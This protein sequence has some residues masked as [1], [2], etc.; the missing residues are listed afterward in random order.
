MRNSLIISL[1]I[2][3]SYIQPILSQNDISSKY[4]FSTIS[5]DDG[6][7]INFVDDIYKDSRGFIWIST[8]G[9]GLVRYDGYEFVPLNVNSYPIS[10]K[11]NFIRKVCEDNYNRLWIASNNGIDI[12]S[13]P[14]MMKSEVYYK[15]NLFGELSKIS[16]STII[17]DSKGS[18]WILAT[19]KI[20][21]LDFDEKGNIQQIYT[22]DSLVAPSIFSTIK[23]IDS[24]I[25]VGHDGS[26]CKVVADETKLLL[27]P[28]ADIPSQGANVFISSV[29]KKGDI[30]WIGTEYGLLKYNSKNKTE[31]FYTHNPTDRSSISQNMVTY[32]SLTN[33]GVLI[34]ATLRGLNFY[35]PVSD[36]FE[37]L[38][39]CSD[40]NTLNNDFINCILPD[41]N[42]L[43]VGTE[44]GGINKMTLRKLA[45]QNY[46]HN[47]YNKNSISPNP[48]NAIYEDQKGNL[49]VGTVE[50]GLNLKRKD[51]K[52]FHHYQS[53]RGLLSHNSVSALEE[54]NDGNLWIG[55]WGGGIDILNLNKLPQTVLKKISSDQYYIGLLKYDS[56][57]NGM[58]IGTNRNIFYYD[59]KTGNIKEPLPK[60]VTMNLMGTLGCIINNKNELWIG[61][62]N[63]LIIADLNSFDQ[64]NYRCDAKFLK[65]DEQEKSQLFLKNITCLYQA[66]D[67][68]IWI[69]SNGYGICQLT[70]EDNRYFYKLYTTTQGLANNTVFGILEDEEGMIWATTCRGISSYNPSTNRFVNYTKNDGLIND[71]FYWNA[72]YKSPVNKNLYFGS[73]G[74]LIELKG[75]NQ[76]TTSEQKKVVFTKLGILNETVWYNE[77]NHIKK[78]IAYADRI[79]L[80]EKDKSFSL[81]FS[82][83]DYDNP[84]TVVYSYR[85][86][87]FD[88]KWIDIDA[89]RRFINY[90]NLRP[91]IYHLQVR[92]MSKAYD[93]SDDITE[94]EIEV[95]PFFYKTNWF[96]GLCTLLLIILT[97]FFYKWR[98][99]SLKKQRTI[100]HKKVDER[101]KELENQKKLL[102]EQA[103]ELKLQNN[104]L[105]TQNEKISIQRKQ[106]IDMSEKVQEAMT[107]R[108]SFFTS[109]THEFRTPITLI[110]GPIER[111]LKLSTNPKV[112]EQLQ[113]VARN[114]KHLLSL[115]NQLMDFRK[116]ESDNMKI[117]P[118]TG[119]LLSYLDEILIPFENFAHERNIEIRKLYRLKDPF[120]MFDEEA[121]RKLI[122]NL[123]SNA[124]KFTP[125]HGIVSLYVNSFFNTKTKKEKL[126]ICVQ[127]SGIGIKEGDLNRIFNR[128]YQSKGHD[129]FPV[130][131]QSGTGIGLYVCKNIVNLSEGDIYAKNNHTE[132]TSFRITIPI[133]REIAQKALPIKKEIEKLNTISESPNNE[134]LLAKGKQKLTIL[135][136]EDNVDMRKY[137]C[138]IL[139]DYYKIVEAENGVEA[140]DI[141]KNRTI[142]FIISDLMMPVMDGLELSQR[143]KADVSISHIPFLMLT[144]KTSLETQIS[145]YK[146]GVDEFLAK[147]FDEELLLTRI[148]NIFESRKIYQRK[149]SLN[150]DV[151]NLNIEKESNDE[152]FLKKAI[153]IIKENYK[154]TDYEVSDFIESMGV[155]KSLLNNKMQML[156]G[157]SAGNF[158]RNYRLS[159]AHELILKSHGNMNIS[160][161][162]YEVGFNDPK[163]F[164][165]CFTKHYGVAPSMV[166]KNGK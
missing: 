97:I 99:N 37:R 44:A 7:P 76:Y 95:H 116:V 118:A 65:L 69:S 39:H 62:S 52:N 139:S 2:L 121:I 115:V 125:D 26:I 106:L 156:T 123:F 140:L 8:Q 22:T 5:I 143:I 162:A 66:K 153:S 73:M 155:S 51:E 158:I 164:T 94:L 71:Q 133:K 138:S 24:E 58:W 134:I 146:I 31:T 157:Q 25:W 92:C 104:I 6:L 57:N 136:V 42:S 23:E 105:F 3:L 41:G 53:G 86:L 82:A 9:G 61:S 89:N 77:N 154:N 56:L 166:N 63:G 48:V 45:V 144:A 4:I 148:N 141:L 12:V 17:K 81:E 30:I 161:I 10:L 46:I 54:D 163:Y 120:I 112:I 43:W 124:I 80:H 91:G 145:S 49:W 40:E 103:I 93:W 27:H 50:G 79:N 72:S 13:L 14:I 152:K 85:L 75:N 88:D 74:G 1:L 127:D 110:V 11:S 102:E 70:S 29:L 33:D 132:G 109:I 18:I 87:G 59:I 131:G 98:I 128:F 68:S 147:P 130:Y 149:F 78:D 38:S 142:D 113:Y 64:T 151:E 55:T 83:L 107:D 100:L 165:R 35:D 34:A 126:Y 84:S 122:T 117:I 90:T 28:I 108:I 60:D 16:A 36:K 111:A 137:I 21:R 150:M 101:T 47:P 20:Y 135:V 32:L 19:N 119:N 96:I 160:E 114:S 67:Q 15:D 129:K 159:I